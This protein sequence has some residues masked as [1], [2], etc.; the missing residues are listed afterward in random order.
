MAAAAILK[1]TKA[2]HD[3]NGLNDFH[4]IFY[5]YRVTLQTPLPT[6]NSYFRKCKMT[7]G[8]C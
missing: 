1:I 4:E 6:E 5:G 2:Q 8:C 3:H 7:T